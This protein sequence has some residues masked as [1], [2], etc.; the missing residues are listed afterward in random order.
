VAEV[1]VAG[2]SPLLLLEAAAH[3]RAGRSV[4]VHTN[5][6]PFGGA[7]WVDDI[8]GF[9][10]VETA[11]HLL[12]ADTI[13]YEVLESVPGVVMEP[14]VPTP[15]VQIGEDRRLR[16]GSAAAVAAVAAIGVPAIARTAWTTGRSAGAVAGAQAAQ[17]SAH[18][19]LRQGRHDLQ[20]R[21]ATVHYPRGGA[22]VLLDRLRSLVE[23]EGADLVD[24]GIDGI[25]VSAPRAPVL[26][27]TDGSSSTP[28][29]VVISGG[30]GGRILDSQNVL[31]APTEE[32]THEQVLLLLPSDSLRPMSYDRFVTDPLLLRASRLD[33]TAVATNVDHN[34]TPLI[35][36]TRRAATAAEVIDALVG[37]GILRERV[38]PAFA[39]S[40]THRSRD[41]A[42]GL[43][44]AVARTAV[45]VVPS[46]GDLSRSLR[47]FAQRHPDWL[48]QRRAAA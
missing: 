5:G 25:D 37:N 10:N 27:Y 19:R 21:G 40:Y 43:E 24:T 18:T 28:D 9:T 48:D 16:Y 44:R 8:A 35:V 38:T 47:G 31:H 34:L 33:R 2:T 23:A 4:T 14:M 30:F 6:A 46:F 26:S 36:G 1:V 7:W 15:M 29:L 22:S 45:Q 39:T 17:R 32:R 11:C 13:G 20:A 3:A 12:E 41:D 42:A